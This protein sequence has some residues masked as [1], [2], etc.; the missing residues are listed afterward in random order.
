MRVIG[1]EVR[2]LDDEVALGVSGHFGEFTDQ[3]AELGATVRIYHPAWRREEGTGPSENPNNN[4]QD[5][6][7]QGQA[8][9]EARPTSK[10]CGNLLP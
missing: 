10:C 2:Y 8:Y 3:L 1:T 4:P 9:G 5:G 7:A 6:I